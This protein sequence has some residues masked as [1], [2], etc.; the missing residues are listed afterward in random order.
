MYKNLL[1]KIDPSSEDIK[2]ADNE[3]WKIVD[4]LV[5]N[6][7]VTDRGD[8]IKQGSY[9][10]QTLTLNEDRKIDLDILVNR[11]E[12]SKAFD[13][14]S[15]ISKILGNRG[16]KVES[17]TRAIRAVKNGFQID[18]LP[19]TTSPIT[20]HKNKLFLMAERGLKKQKTIDPI[21]YL[22]WLKTSKSNTLYGINT[23][24]IKRDIDRET[25]KKQLANS[26][27]N[28]AIRIIKFLGYGFDYKSEGVEKISS[29]EIECIISKSSIFAYSLEEMVSQALKNI[30]IFA[31]EG[32]DFNNPAY[33]SE[34]IIHFKGKK[35]Y[36]KF[37][38]Y[39]R[40]E[41]KK[42]VPKTGSQKY[43]KFGGIVLLSSAAT[44]TTS[45]MGVVKKTAIAASATASAA[46]HYGGNAKPTIYLNGWR[47]RKNIVKFMKKLSIKEVEGVPFVE[48][49]GQLTGREYK[50]EQIADKDLVKFLPKFTVKDDKHLFPEDKSICLSKK[51][52]MSPKKRIA[53]LMSWVYAYEY[54][55]LFNEWGWSEV[56]H[57]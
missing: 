34:K 55:L 47:K 32:Q 39:A 13:V 54:Y 4:I 29:F 36:I 10:T 48:L 15:S 25:Y 20:N 41:L 11:H 50:F 42:L 17:K 51:Y 56:K 14:K 18:I 24:E 2:K 3:Y 53:Q 40:N 35:K 57:G 19:V 21:G 27:I 46:G 26:N 16:Y 5:E 1:K 31:N 49:K 52:I 12:S 33:P 44:L 23:T 9:K 43:I 8:I 30:E 22:N 6:K 37:V 28:Q 45:S 7:I 38:E